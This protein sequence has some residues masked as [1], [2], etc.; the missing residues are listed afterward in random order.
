MGVCVEMLDFAWEI[1]KYVNNALVNLPNKEIS[2]ALRKIVCGNKNLLGKNEI[3]SD[4]KII[5]EV[6]RNFM[7]PQF[8]FL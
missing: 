6:H 5:V 2:D 4:I 8:E 7:N 1:M 3:R